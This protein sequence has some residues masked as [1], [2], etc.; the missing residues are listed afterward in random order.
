METEVLALTQ[1]LLDAISRRDWAAY[2]ELCDPGLTCFEPEACGQ[3]VTGLP[4][5][6]F[7]FADGASEARVQSTI[8][9]PVVH[10]LGPDAAVVAYTR[11]IQTRDG[12]RAFEETRVWKRV[13]GCWWHVHFHRSPVTT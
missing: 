2:T 4:F 9:S 5:H 1:R 12:E 7:Y 10:A 3:L 8:C 11:V 6:Q 13:D